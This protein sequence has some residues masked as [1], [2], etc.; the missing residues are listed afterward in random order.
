MRAGELLRHFDF[1]LLGGM[2]IIIIFG[3]LMINSAVAGNI[4]LIEL[5]VVKRQAIYASLGLVV[6]VGMTLLD[7]HLWI[8]FGRIMYVLLLGILGFLFATG[9]AAFGSARWLNLGGLPIQPS[10]LAKITIIVVMADVFT[11]NREQIGN[12]L[13]VGRSLIITMGLMVFIVLQPD[14]STSIVLMVIWFALLWA[15]GLK[16]K[17]L[18]LFAAVGATA[19]VVAFPFL[20]AYQQQRV[21]NFLFPDPEARYGEEYNVVQSQISLGS[22]GLFGQGYQQGSQVQL[23]YLKVRHND[24]IFSAIGEELGFA[25]NVFVILMLA[26]VIWRIMVVA[27][28]APDMYGS[29]ICYGVATLLFF[30]GFVNIGMNLKLMPV[31]GLPLP[32]ISYGG[33]SLLSMM[34]GIGLVQSVAA[35]RRYYDTGEPASNPV[36][37]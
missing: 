4:E 1:V 19:V 18:L 23:R 27:Q 20:E 6:I 5:E 31:T 10:E 32:F 17:H 9:D 11:R 7:Y 12:L 16:W 24:F 14:L 28:T 2:I 22:G 33:S 15:S 30:H 37:S 36:A 35:R 13:F 21:I 34:M 29:L 8:T 3:V 26:F 25:G